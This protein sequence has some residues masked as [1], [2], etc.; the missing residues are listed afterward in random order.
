MPVSRARSI[1]LSLRPLAPSAGLVDVDDHGRALVEGKTLLTQH[2]H[3]VGQH[4]PPI[5]GV[6]AAVIHGEG[7][8][9][10]VALGADETGPA[11]AAEGNDVAISLAVV[12]ERVAEEDH[13]PQRLPGAAQFL[14]LV[15]EP[16]GGFGIVRILLAGN[17]IGAQFH[18]QVGGAQS[19]QPLI[20]RF[21]V[22]VDDHVT[23]KIR[24]ASP[25]KLGVIGNLRRTG[26]NTG[27][28]RHW[29]YSSRTTPGHGHGARLGADHALLFTLAGGN[30]PPA[31]NRRLSQSPR[32]ACTVV[33]T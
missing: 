8:R 17:L 15:Q 29:L 27:G 7:G 32:H 24:Q 11:Q 2:R 30:S 21:K 5:G 6:D 22:A 26:D 4:L 9:L 3:P 25:A 14:N 33:Q 1:T 28:R 10:L 18:V 23:R 31:R 12:E 19:R 16:G 13:L 20:H